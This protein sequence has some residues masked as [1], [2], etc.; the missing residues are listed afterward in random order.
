MELGV[1]DEPSF[2]WLELGVARAAFSCASDC[3][4]MSTQHAGNTVQYR[5]ENREV[6][7]EQEN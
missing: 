4:C 1:S 6:L 5:E 7:R 3:P 2:G